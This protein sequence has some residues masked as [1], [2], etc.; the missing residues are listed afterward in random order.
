M[1]AAQCPSSS[2]IGLKC[3]A[4]CRSAPP[5]TGRL[6]ESVG[7]RPSLPFLDRRNTLVARRAL[8]T[9][10]RTGQRHRP[11]I[12]PT[13]GCKRCKFGRGRVPRPRTHAQALQTPSG[14]SYFREVSSR[15]HIRGNRK[16]VLCLGRVV[17][18]SAQIPISTCSRLSRRSPRPPG[19]FRMRIAATIRPAISVGDC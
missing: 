4:C 6:I 3:N 11:G 2:G 9:N 16:K 14:L 7:S 5:Q 15:F 1:Q 17:K 13:N 10:R 12:A 18:P 19:H 8:I